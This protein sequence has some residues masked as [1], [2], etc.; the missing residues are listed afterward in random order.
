VANRNFN[1][2]QALEK[3]IKDLYANVSI[4]SVVSGPSMLNSAAAYGILGASAV[5]NSVGSTSIQGN[6]GLYPGT[7]VSGTF[8]VSGATNVANAAAQQ[9]QLDALA[10]YTTLAAHASTTIPSALDGQTLS[11]GYYSFAS[12]AATLAQSAPGTLTLNGSATDIFV[13]KTASTLT[14]GA[15]GAA[16]ISLTGG[17][18]ASNVFFIVGSSATINSGTAGVH[19]GNIIAQASITD[20]LG[21]TINGNLIALTGAVT[22]SAAAV[23]VAQPLNV[24]TPVLNLS[25]GFKSVVRNSAG[26]YTLTLQDHYMFLKAFRVMVVSAVAEDLTFQL[27]AFSVDPVITPSVPNTPATIE[28][29]CLKAG[30]PTD[31]QFADVLLIKAELKNTSAL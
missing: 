11:A 5:T 23:I 21:G 24:I 14:T 3:E 25:P 31:P 15:G 6:L 19:N 8:V 27:K 13:I 26:D 7:S 16:T 12:G 20:T 29:L 18:V 9:A 30:V 10:V 1:R 22:I 4:T 2:R 17:A 28:F